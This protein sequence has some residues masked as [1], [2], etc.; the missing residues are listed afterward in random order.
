MI[1]KDLVLPRGG[2]TSRGRL[3]LK[4]SYVIRPGW[5][6]THALLCQRLNSIAQEGAG[7]AVHGPFNHAL[8][9]VDKQAAEIHERHAVLLFQKLQCT[10]ECV[11]S[12]TA[13]LALIF[14]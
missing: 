8:V 10:D 7:I 6:R 5:L 1:G 9:V 3:F 12:A 13:E 14:E 11:R 2:I 4:R